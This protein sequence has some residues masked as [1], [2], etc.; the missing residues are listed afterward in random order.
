[1]NKEFNELVSEILEFQWKKSPVEATFLGVHEYDD[2]LDKT[3]PESRR[4][5][6]KKTKEYLNGLNRY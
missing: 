2:K 4:R 5:Y 3:D 1:M 6:L